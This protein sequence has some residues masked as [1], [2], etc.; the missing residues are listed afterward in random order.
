MDS[1]LVL[2]LIPGTNIQITFVIWILLSLAIA[3]FFVFLYMKR[4]HLFTFW[5]LA[6]RLHRQL[7]R[8]D[9]NQLTWRAS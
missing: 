6:L 7:S 8:V 1:L 3:A 4:R 5:L 9:S 2:G